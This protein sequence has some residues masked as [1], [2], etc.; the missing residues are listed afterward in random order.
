MK[1]CTICGKVLWPWQART[2]SY[3]G[4]NAHIGCIMEH[5]ENYLEEV[6]DSIIKRVESH[7]LPKKPYI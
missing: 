2:N 3:H 7:R 6:I 4:R 1:R 5:D